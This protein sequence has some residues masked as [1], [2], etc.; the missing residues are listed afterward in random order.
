MTLWTVV[1]F[2]TDKLQPLN[3]T[4]NKKYND[5]F[6]SQFQNWYSDQVEK[7]LSKKKDDDVEMRTSKASPCEMSNQNNFGKEDNFIVGSCSTVLH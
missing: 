6:K 7:K 4:I 3:Q 1:M 5:E 2:V